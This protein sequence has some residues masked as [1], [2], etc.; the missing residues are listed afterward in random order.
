MAYNPYSAVEQIVNYKKLYDE[1]EKAGDTAKRDEVAKK[2]Q[3]YYKQLRQNS[4]GD[5]AD[6]LNA[7]GYNASLNILDSIG[8]VGRETPRQVLPTYFKQFSIPYDDTKMT[9]DDL[10]GEVKYDGISMGKSDYMGSNDRTYFD[11]G[12]IQ[13]FAKQYKDIV[14]AGEKPVSKM[15]N[16][17]Q[18]RVNENYGKLVDSVNNLENINNPLQTQW[19]RDIMEVFGIKG[20][21]AADN[22]VATAAA[23]NSGNIDSFA[24]ANA[25]RQQKAFSVSGIQAVE[26][27]RQ[28]RIADVRAI[29]SDMGVNTQNMFQNWQTSL[30]NQVARDTQIMNTTGD[31][32]P[33]YSGN[34]YIGANMDFQAEINKLDPVKDAEKIN[35]L[36]EARAY[37]IKTSKDPDINSLPFDSFTPTTKETAQLRLGKAQL[38]ANERMTDKQLASNERIAGMEADANKY[39]SDNTVLATGVKIDENNN[40]E[41][42]KLYDTNA[43]NINKLYKKDAGMEL[44]ISDGNGNYKLNPKLTPEDRKAYLDL[45]IARTIENTALSGEERVAFL[46]SLGV[47]QADMERVYN[48]IPK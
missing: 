32:L 1:Y 10:T 48:Y 9:Y 35:L 4:Y 38:E 40:K 39:V 46:E 25:K 43:D 42:L 29:L 28:Q 37:K 34:P 36:K 23:G 17:E 47:S 21:N 26:A 15:Y 5:I 12:R 16:Q 45:I 22:E 6:K 3:E 13:D 19:G 2:A 24:A 11:T 27:A 41:L 33:Q 18:Q 31:I 20:K 30:N 7:S 8:M 14:G 44:I